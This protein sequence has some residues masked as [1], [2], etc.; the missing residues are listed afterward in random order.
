MF[1]NVYFVFYSKTLVTE[2]VYSLKAIVCLTNLNFMNMVRY[3]LFVP[4][5]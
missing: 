5:K 2:A 4:M 1:L 3:L